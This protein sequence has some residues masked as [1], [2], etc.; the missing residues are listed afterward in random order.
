VRLA[1]EARQPLHS[2][3]LSCSLRRRLEIGANARDSLR[4]WIAAV[5]EIEH[6]ARISNDISSKAGRSCVISAQEF[7]YFSEQIHLSFSL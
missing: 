3:L 1:P 5:A 6:K 2:T 4:P 7:F